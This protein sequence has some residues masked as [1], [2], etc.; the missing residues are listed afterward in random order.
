[1][2][3][4]ESLQNHFARDSSGRNAAFILGVLVFLF[5]PV[6]LFVA[7]PSYLKTGWKDVLSSRYW[8]E[9][10][11]VAIRGLWWLLGGAVGFAILWLVGAMLAI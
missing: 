11:A 8:R 4:I 3:A 5:V 6:L 2:A 1:M 10:R 9:L 7:G